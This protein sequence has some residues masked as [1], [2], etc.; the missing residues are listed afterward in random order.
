MYGN[1]YK[2]NI[3]FFFDPHFAHSVLVSTHSL[4]I[5]LLYAISMIC[6]WFEWICCSLG[7]LCAQAWPVLC[8]RWRSWATRS[9]LA[10]PGVRVSLT[11]SDHHLMIDWRQLFARPLCR[12]TYSCLGSS[13]MALTAI[14]VFI[15]YMKRNF[16]VSIVRRELCLCQCTPNR[17]TP[18]SVPTIQ[19]HSNWTS[20]LCFIA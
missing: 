4:I 16:L 18:K 6:R 11:A 3:Y 1:G 14:H 2:S 13:Y 5:R 7:W 9:H 10:E 15:L 19:V 12:L 17:K 8:R 20:N